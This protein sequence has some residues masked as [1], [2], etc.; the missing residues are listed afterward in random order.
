MRMSYEWE[1]DT[2]PLTMMVLSSLPLPSR[3]V[4]R[5][6]FRDPQ[7]HKHLAVLDRGCARIPDDACER[8]HVSASVSTGLCPA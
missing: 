2:V 4:L 6:W 3:V 5:V 1:E 7:L 8:P